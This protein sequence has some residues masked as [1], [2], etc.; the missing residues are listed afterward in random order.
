MAIGRA[1]HCDPGRFRRVRNYFLITDMLGLCARAGLVTIAALSLSGCLVDRAMSVRAQMCG[2]DDLV[3]ISSDDGVRVILHE[4]V[5]H[6]DDITRVL[7]VA[8]FYTETHGDRL[9]MRYLVRKLPV[10]GEPDWTLPFDLSF[11]LVDGRYKLQGFSVETDLP[12]SI[13]AESIEQMTSASCSALPSL[14]RRSIEIE[15]SPEEIALAPTRAEVLSLAG[16]PT[17]ANA[18]LTE[19]HYEF[20]IRGSEDDHGRASVAMYFDASGEKLTRVESS[21]RR[22]RMDADFQTGIASARIR[23][24]GTASTGE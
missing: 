1:G 24:S 21:F 22:F 11:Q 6:D 16:V 19:I 14:W 4:P 17:R 10:R 23:H 13:D 7:G 8:P 20:T 15:M 3:E 5:L 2:D 18:D 12:I 9:E